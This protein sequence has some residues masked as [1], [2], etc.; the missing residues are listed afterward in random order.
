MAKA[1]N[2]T[3]P[4]WVRSMAGLDDGIRRNVVFVFDFHTPT[5]PKSEDNFASLNCWK[6]LK[7]LQWLA[8]YAGKRAHVGV[9]VIP[10]FCF[11]FPWHWLLVERTPEDKANLEV[12]AKPR[13]TK[14]EV[15]DVGRRH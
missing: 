15:C 10:R 14:V 12:E 1:R 4:L 3:S 5:V 13:A 11:D 2:R 9:R 7:R 6:H 8:N